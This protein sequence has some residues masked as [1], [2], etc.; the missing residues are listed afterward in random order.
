MKVIAELTNSIIRNTKV[1]KDWEESY[2]TNL[3]I[4]KDHGLRRGTS[5]VSGFWNML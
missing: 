3:Y 5:K 2:I 1:V 4:E